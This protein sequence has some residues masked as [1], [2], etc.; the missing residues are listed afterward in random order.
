MRRKAKIDGGKRYFFCRRWEAES[1]G[2]SSD[3]FVYLSRKINHRPSLGASRLVRAAASLDGKNETKRMNAEEI[4]Q[5]FDEAVD[6]LL[7]L[8]DESV[9]LAERKHRLTIRR[10]LNKMYRFH[11]MQLEWFDADDG[12][13]ESETLAEI[14][15]HLEPLGLADYGTP[16]AELARLAALKIAEK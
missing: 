5:K 10:E 1:E 14:R 16:L 15:Q 13:A 8:C 4:K 9:D 3:G 12:G 11:L 6:Y 7:Q 2:I